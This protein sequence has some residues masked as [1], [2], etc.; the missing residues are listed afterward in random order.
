MI[1]KAILVLDNVTMLAHGVRG[2]AVMFF[3]NIGLSGGLFML[4][5]RSLC[6]V[7]IVSRRFFNNVPNIAH[8]DGRNAPQDF[9]QTWEVLPQ[10]SELLTRSEGFAF[11]GL[12]CVIMGAHVQSTMKFTCH[13]SVNLQEGCFKCEKVTA[14]D[15]VGFMRE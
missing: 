14:P 1:K 3:Q 15:T 5:V 13:K 4:G 8:S 9:W 6:F 12:G 7:T 2:E 11:C 10:P